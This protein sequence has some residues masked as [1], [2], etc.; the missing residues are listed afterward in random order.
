LEIRLERIT[1][2]LP[3]G[4][5]NLRLE[6]RAEGHSMLDT[7][8]REWASGAMRFDRPGEMLVA[9]YS[10]DVLAGIGGM[11]LEPAIP[12]ALRMRRFYVALAYR[13]HG[14]GRALAAALLDAARRQGCAVTCNAAGGSERFW[15]ALGFA[16]DRRDGW[17]HLLA[18]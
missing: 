10:G 2:A 12:G 18:R 3:E 17:T 15:Q 7:L 4:F 6:A 11:T 1:T 14:V 9:A 16:P 13:R 5:E 8:A